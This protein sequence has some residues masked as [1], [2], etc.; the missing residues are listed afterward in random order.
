MILYPLCTWPYH[1][2]LLM[3]FIIFCFAN[4][5]KCCSV[6]RLQ[7]FQQ[8]ILFKIQQREYLSPNRSLLVS[9]PASA[10]SPSCSWQPGTGLSLLPQEGGQHT[11]FLGSVHG[12]LKEP[13]YQQPFAPL[14]HHDEV[15]SH[16]RLEEAHPHA[17][18]RA[19]GKEFSWAFCS[20][21][22]QMHT[23]TH[24]HPFKKPTL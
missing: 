4:G 21:F 3:G 16:S 5:V 12:F 1:T 7:D 15:G 14:P 8:G 24:S 20:K 11:P 17:Y 2:Y 10:P 23:L 6:L 9:R 13:V 18:A 22:T 19:I